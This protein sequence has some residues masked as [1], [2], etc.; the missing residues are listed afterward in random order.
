MRHMEL[1]I[2]LIHY[3][4]ELIKINIHKVKLSELEIS[5]F[6]LFFTCRAQKI[7]AHIMLWMQMD[8]ST[9]RSLDMRIM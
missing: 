5:I 3:L 4:Y 8:I 6:G 1:L 9:I 7:D 2:Y